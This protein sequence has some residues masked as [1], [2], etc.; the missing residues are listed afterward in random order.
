[1]KK[2]IVDIGDVS[3]YFLYIGQRRYNLRPNWPLGQNFGLAQASGPF[4]LG[5]GLCLE[6]Q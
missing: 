2:D 4:G 3:R 5:V 6:L 1:M